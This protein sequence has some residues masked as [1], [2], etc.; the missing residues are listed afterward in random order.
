MT[1]QASSPVFTGGIRLQ[2]QSKHGSED[3]RLEGRSMKQSSIHTAERFEIRGLLSHALPFFIVP[4][5]AL[6][7]IL[8]A[9]ERLFDLGDPIGRT[10]VSLLRSC[11]FMECDSGSH[12]EQDS[13]DN[14]A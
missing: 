8:G 1:R 4:I 6:L 12:Y 14:T 5:V 9:N 10:S 13:H 3:G 11:P 2:P 7:T